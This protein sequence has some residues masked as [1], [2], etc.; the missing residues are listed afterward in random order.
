[1]SDFSSVQEEGKEPFIQL[2]ILSLSSILK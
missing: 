1:V 2:K